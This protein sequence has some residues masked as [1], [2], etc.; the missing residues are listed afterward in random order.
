MNWLTGGGKFEILGLFLYGN[1]VGLVETAAFGA[2]GKVI[3]YL[4]PRRQRQLIVPV[5]IGVP[6]HVCAGYIAV[7]RL[8][9]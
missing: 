9:G 5:S 3:A 6:F 7:S 1:S 2:L 8:S 4:I